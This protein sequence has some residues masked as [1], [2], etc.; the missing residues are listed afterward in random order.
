MIAFSL[1]HVNKNTEEHRVVR[2][3]KYIE[4]CAGS[5]CDY[6]YSMTDVAICDTCA[7]GHG[8]PLDGTVADDRVRGTS[9]F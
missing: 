3:G 5:N 6:M 2:N 8:Y 7:G 9:T 4:C 1:K